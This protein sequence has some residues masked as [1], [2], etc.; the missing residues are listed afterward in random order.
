MAAMAAIRSCPTLKAFALRLTLAGKPKRLILTAVSRK[1]I[2]R[3]NS[4]LST[5]SPQLT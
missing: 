3:A 5:I 4:A 2:V 1:L